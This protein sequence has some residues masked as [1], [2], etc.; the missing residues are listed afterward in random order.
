[1]FVLSKLLNVLTQPLAWVVALL[2]VGLLLQRRWRRTGQGLLWAALLV[3]LLQGWEP[4][5]DAVLRQLEAQQ[6]A[7][8]PLDLSR[9]AG[10]IVLGG[11][12]E[13]SYVWEGHAQPALNSAAE[14]LTAALPL[15]QREP[16]LVLLYTGGEGELLASGP[17]EAERARRFYVEQ[18]VPPARLLLE[19]ASR[20]THDNAVF[21]AAL[22]GVDRTRPWLLITSAW[23]MPRSLRTFRKAGWNVTPWPTDYR[24]GLTTPWHQYSLS[25]GAAKWQLALHELLGLAAY[26]LRGWL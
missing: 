1:M 22:P 23:H 21:S 13:S 9:Y 8:D 18:G 16:R 25:Q 11:S 15:L 2:F 14:R 4:L 20:N 17:S 19:S 10:V 6:P 7:P 3:L 12:T 24:A 5:P 26:R